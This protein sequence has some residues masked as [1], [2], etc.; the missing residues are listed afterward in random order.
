MQFIVYLLRD[1][2]LRNLFVSTNK[3]GAR[4]IFSFCLYSF[5]V[6]TVPTVKTCVSTCIYI[7]IYMHIYTISQ[8]MSFLILYDFS[9]SV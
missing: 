8:I 4:F 1:G 3:F 6:H 7:Y 2:L 9:E 5:S